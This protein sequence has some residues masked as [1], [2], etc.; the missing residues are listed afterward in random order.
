MAKLWVRYDNGETDD[1]DLTDELGKDAAKFVAD[2]GHAGHTGNI[3][4]FAVMPDE[5]IPGTEYGFVTLRMD[6]LVA[7]HVDGLVNEAATAAL[8]AEIG[9]SSEDPNERD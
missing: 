3:F 5:G 6:R 9:A 7:W 8:W 2:M 1:W 4:G